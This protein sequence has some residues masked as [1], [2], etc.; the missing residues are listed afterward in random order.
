M[1][2]GVSEL[3]NNTHWLKLDSSC[4]TRKQLS[5]GMVGV[6]CMQYEYLTSNLLVVKRK[7]T[8][9]GPELEGSQL[10]ICPVNSGF[11]ASDLLLFQKSLITEI[12]RGKNN[13][14]CESETSQRKLFVSKKIL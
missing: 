3:E 12:R 7:A 6:L 13:C 8:A 9:L 1:A 5:V 2:L 4:F 11:T 10:W 14:Y